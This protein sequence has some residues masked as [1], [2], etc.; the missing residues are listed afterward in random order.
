M[1]KRKATLSNKSLFETDY[2]TDERERYRCTQRIER[3]VRE[4]KTDNERGMTDRMKQCVYCEGRRRERGR[5]R[6]RE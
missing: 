3:Y 6:E 4:K 1:K 2:A 5:E